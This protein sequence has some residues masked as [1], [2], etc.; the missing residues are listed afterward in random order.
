MG[1][2]AHIFCRVVSVVNGYHLKMTCYAISVLIFNN[3]KVNS[4][5]RYRDRL[6]KRKN[7]KYFNFITA[8][9]T[10]LINNVYVYEELKILYEAIITKVLS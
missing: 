2:K 8:H 10:G 3:P 9:K 4:K 1:G 6:G 7:R 5:A